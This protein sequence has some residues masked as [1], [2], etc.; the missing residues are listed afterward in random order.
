MFTT[1]F[2][3]VC[4]KLLSNRCLWRIS[5][6]CL[7]H[8]FNTWLN[9]RF[10]QALKWAPLGPIIDFLPSLMLLG[11]TS[12]MPLLVNKSKFKVTCGETTLL[13]YNHVSV[14]SHATSTTWST[15]CNFNHVSVFPRDASTTS[16]LSHVTLQ[17]HVNTWFKC[18]LNHA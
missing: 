18:Y 14:S 13:N 2:N 4:K 7:R 12:L 9:P 6:T 16:Y 1:Y 17:P 15:T 5:T 3:Y 10:F 11:F 8:L